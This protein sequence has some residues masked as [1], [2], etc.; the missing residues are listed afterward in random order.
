MMLH[1][2]SRMGQQAGFGNAETGFG[3]GNIGQG[4]MTGGGMAGGGMGGGP[5][6]MGG[7]ADRVYGGQAAGYAMG[8]A[9][10]YGANS[11][12]NGQVCVHTQLL[13]DSQHTCHVVVELDLN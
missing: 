8:Q 12:Y 7:G 4:S 11:G 3:A 2:C 13:K 9:M 6:G 10:N 5:A 1:G